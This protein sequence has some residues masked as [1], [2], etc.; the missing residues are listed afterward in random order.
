LIVEVYKWIVLALSIS[1]DFWVRWLVHEAWH[2]IRAQGLEFESW[3]SQF[4]VKIAVAP[5]CVHVLTF[6]SP[7]C[8]HVLTFSSPVTREWGCWSI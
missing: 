1:S 8:V 2:G 3:F 4:I 7:I 5:L 6:S